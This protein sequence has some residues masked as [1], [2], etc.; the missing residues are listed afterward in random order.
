MR[1]LAENHIWHHT[2]EAEQRNAH[3]LLPMHE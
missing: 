1:S 2:Q 3:R